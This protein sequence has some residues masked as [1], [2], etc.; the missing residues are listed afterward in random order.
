MSPVHNNFSKVVKGEEPR[1]SCF[2]F[3]DKKKDAEASRK[4]KKAD[5]AVPKTSSVSSF[6]KPRPTAAEAPTNEGAADSVETER[7]SSIRPSCEKT[8]EK[9]V[10]EKADAAEN[11]AANKAAKAKRAAPERPGAAMVKKRRV[12]SIESFEFELSGASAMDFVIPE[13]ATAGKATFVWKFD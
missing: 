1:T 2:S 6:W 9:A 12:E 5:D 13:G 11:D 8:T 3:K 7:T 4:S 10:A